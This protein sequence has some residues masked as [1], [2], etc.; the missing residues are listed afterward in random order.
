MELKLKLKEKLLTFILLFTAIFSSCALFEEEKEEEKA[1]VSPVFFSVPGGDYNEDQSVELSTVTEG[2]SIYYTTDGSMPNTGSTLY[3]KPVIITGHDTST[4]LKAI[5]VK[6]GYNNSLLSERVYNLFYIQ[7]E[8]PYFNITSGVYSEDKTIEISTYQTGVE[9]YYTMDGTDPTTSSSKYT[10]PIDIAGHGTTVTIKAITAQK[11]KNDS[12]IVTHTYEINY[13]KCSDPEFNYSGTQYNRDILVELSARTAGAKIYYTT[14]G[15]E[16]TVDSAPYTNPIPVSGHGTTMT[17]KAFATA[18]GLIDSNMVSKTYTINHNECSSP[19][20]SIDG[21]VKDYDFTFTLRTTTYNADIYYTIDGSEPTAS[22]LKYTAPI[23]VKGHGTE[24]TYK[25]IAIKDGLLNSPVVSMNYKIQYNKCSNPVFSISDG[26]HSSDINIEITNTTSQSD[27]YYTKDGSEP[28]KNSILYTGPIKLEGPNSQL[29]IKAVSIYRYPSLLNSDVISKNYSVQ[30]PKCEPPVVTEPVTPIY[31]YENIRVRASTPGSTIH[32]TLDGSTPTKS[33]SYLSDYLGW[34]DIKI[35]NIGI[36]TVKIVAIKNGYQNS[37]VITRVYTIEKMEVPTGL[38]VKGYAS[39]AVLFTWDLLPG[40]STYKVTATSRDSSVSDIAT[41]FNGNQGLVTDLRSSNNYKF[42]I[43][44]VIGSKV[45]DKGAVLDVKPRGIDYSIAPPSNMKCTYG[46]PN[47]VT[48][49]P[50]ITSS[51][52]LGYLVKIDDVGS[53]LGYPKE[54]FVED[55]RFEFNK[56]SSKTHEVTVTP[57]TTSYGG[58][59][60][61][62]KIPFQAPER[63]TTLSIKPIDNKSVELT[64]TMPAGDIPIDGYYIYK[65]YLPEPRATINNP[66]T[67]TFKMEGL[68]PSRTYN[69]KVSAFNSLGRS[70]STSLVPVTTYSIATP[71][72]APTGN[73]VGIGYQVEWNPIDGAVKYNVY[74]AIDDSAYTLIKTTTEL[75]FDDIRIENGVYHWKVTAVDASGKESNFS[76]IVSIR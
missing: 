58:L 41:Y 43:A 73:F 19:V 47:V 76:N 8:V 36:N 44:A 37:D 48:W 57:V 50:V 64:W 1:T 29:N 24:I 28:S 34:R 60:G 33:S 32:Y 70:A 4:T 9:I 45:G 59:I 74:R 7:C 5:A 6:D 62:L 63:P 35:N 2:A 17:I 56:E 21:G 69:Y 25:A 11:G 52:V 16:P 20:F 15:S 23:E 65:D 30:Y 31:E 49:D 38:K 72:L 3:T 66:N 22:S 42:T 75:I 51:T 46:S 12:E 40:V 61:I 71:I 67:T 68:A 53:S 10:T 55:T 26:V 13:N 14:D 39:G 54:Y 18:N 27:I